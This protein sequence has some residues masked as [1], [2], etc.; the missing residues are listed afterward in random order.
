MD[1]EE[2]LEEIDMLIVTMGFVPRTVLSWEDA[3]SIQ[4]YLKEY[5][6]ILE[7][8]LIKKNTKE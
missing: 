3:R 6:R 2:K 8:D 1:I 5:K 7:K 4:T